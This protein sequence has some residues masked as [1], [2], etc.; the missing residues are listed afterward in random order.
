MTDTEHVPTSSL[1]EFVRD[2]G[3]EI[4]PTMP[5]SRDLLWAAADRLLAL[6]EERDNLLRANADQFMR[7]YKPVLD[8]LADDER[9]D[10]GAL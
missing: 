8:A 3:D 5:L 4:R 1:V 2:I 9:A 10:E 6:T 7:H